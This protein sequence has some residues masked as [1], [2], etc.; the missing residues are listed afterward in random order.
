MSFSWQCFRILLV[1][2]SKSLNDLTGN[3]L[4][5]SDPTILSEG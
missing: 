1:W 5:I 4:D 3:L 2:R